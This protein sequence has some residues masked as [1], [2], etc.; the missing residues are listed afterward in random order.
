[1]K[2]LNSAHLALI[3][4]Y[5]N[6]SLTYY[7]SNIR[8][9][10]LLLTWSLHFICVMNESRPLTSLSWIRPGFQSR[11]IISVDSGLLLPSSLNLPPP[12]LKA[13]VECAYPAPIWLAEAC[14]RW[15]PYS[16]QLPHTL[17]P[18]P[19][20][21]GTGPSV[22]LNSNPLRSQQQKSLINRTVEGGG[23]GGR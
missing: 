12:P 18:P 17:P 9:N 3:V 7:L 16:P 21:P 15:M 11:I 14:G 20:T 8:P 22:R 13:E 23:G 1:M 19:P 6:S 10:H 2:P 4:H 5:W